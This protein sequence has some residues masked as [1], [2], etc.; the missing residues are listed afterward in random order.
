MG[1]NGESIDVYMSTRDKIAGHSNDAATLAGDKASF[2]SGY[3]MSGYGVN[4]IEIQF[5]RRFSGGRKFAKV[6]RH[7]IGHVTYIA[8][9]TL[10]YGDF[11]RNLG[12][13]EGHNG[14]NNDDPSGLRAD[15]YTS[16]V[17]DWLP[18]QRAI[19]LPTKQISPFP[20]PVKMPY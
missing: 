5:K 13:T 15:R 16:R 3:V 8:H 14:H 20:T 19:P 10:A 4:T 1:E 9:N 12:T 11:L 6:A 2:T 17:G 18:P 7:E